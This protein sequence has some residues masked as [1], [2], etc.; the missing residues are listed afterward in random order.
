MI[1]IKI[2]RH[3]LEPTWWRIESIDQAGADYPTRLQVNDIINGDLARRLYASDRFRV[4]LVSS[5]TDRTDIV[6]TWRSVEV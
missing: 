1:T 2:R 3:H 5:V 6:S 4:L